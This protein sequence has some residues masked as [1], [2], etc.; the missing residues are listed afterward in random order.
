[1]D[2][3][4]E[5]ASLVLREARAPLPPR[6][7]LRR[8]LSA[9]I[10]PSSLYGKTQHKTLQARLSEDILL[11]RERSPFFRTKPGYFFLREFLTDPAIP[12]EY[13]VPI[14]ARRRR[15]ELAYHHALAFDKDT[16]QEICDRPVVKANAVLKLL[17]AHHYHYAKSSQDR[18]PNDVLIWSFV[19]V[20]RRNCALTYRHGRFRE[21]RDT[22]LQKRSIGF[23]CP[24]VHD[25]LTLFDQDDHGIV[26]SG[27]RAL[28]V[29]LHLDS[30]VQLSRA[31]ELKAFICTNENTTSNLLGVIALQAPDWLEP[32][33]RRLAINDLAWHDLRTQT[34]HFE[35]FDPWSQLILENTKFVLEDALRGSSDATPKD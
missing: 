7:I 5:I 6:E 23:F 28:S 16:A 3:Y 2:A 29:D 21:D 11:R 14:V 13:R 15:R 34:N 4:L 25:D 31:A 27:M 24:V 10:V 8:G 35:D 32:I 9:G 18:A 33:S 20:L 26:A 12:S 19:V 1:M 22:F 17:H 30:D